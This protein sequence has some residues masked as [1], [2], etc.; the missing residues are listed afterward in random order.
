MKNIVT[1]KGQQAETRENFLVKRTGSGGEGGTEPGIFPISHPEFYE[2]DDPWDFTRS[3]SGIP[4]S[5]PS[6][7][8]HSWSALQAALGLFIPL[9]AQNSREGEERHPFE[10]EGSR[11]VTPPSS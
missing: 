9:P 2:E 8:C 5:L 7:P 6:Y 10:F 3:C 4:S 1:G 11:L